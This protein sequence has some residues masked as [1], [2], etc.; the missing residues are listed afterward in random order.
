MVELNFDRARPAA[1]IDLGRVAELRGWRRRTGALRLGAGSRTPRRCTRNWRRRSPRS[2]RRRAPSARRRSATAGTIGGNLGTAS[3]AGDAC[4]R[5]WSSGAEVELAS[6]R[7]RGR[8]PS[9]EFLLGPEAQ[10]ARRR[11]AD[12][13][14]ASRPRAAADVHEGRAARNAMV[15]AVCSFALALDRER[16]ELG[17]RS[18]RPAR[19]GL[20]TGPLDEADALPERGRRA[21]RADRRR[22][23]H[24]RLPPPRARRAGAARRSR[25]A[26]A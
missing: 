7:G 23:R 9:S 10:R 22:A 8:M 14:G 26:A 25:G 19:A 2:R 15:I 20:V 18:A 6:V 16:G 1:M 24:R 4:R 11:R 5:C 3:P 13:R 12:H 17:R 21:L